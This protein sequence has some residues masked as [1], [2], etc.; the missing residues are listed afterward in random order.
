[1][2]DG[3]FPYLQHPH[4]PDGDLADDGIVLCLEELLDGYD[5]AGLAV[6]ALVDGTVRALAQLT[7]LL[8]LFQPARLRG[9]LRLRVRTSTS[10]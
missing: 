10:R 3:L 8:V 4:L 1:M 7:E 6:S 9:R 5:L 2:R